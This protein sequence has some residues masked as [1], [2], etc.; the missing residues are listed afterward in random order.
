MANWR[1]T[2]RRVLAGTADANIRFE[3]LRNLLTRLSFNE[4]IKGDHYI[5]SRED[6]EAI[7]NLQPQNGMTKPYQ[8]GQVRD[9]IVEA[10][11]VEFDNQDDGDETEPK[12]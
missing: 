10:R 9:V 6:I 12:K 7:L 11:L 8:V 1:K 4:R 5:F 3:D 2:L